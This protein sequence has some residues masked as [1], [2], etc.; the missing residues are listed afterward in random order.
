MLSDRDYTKARFRQSPPRVNDTVLKPLII[1]NIIVYVMQEMSRHTLT[2]MISLDFG[3]LMQGQVWRLGTHMFAHGGLGHIFFNMWG[4]WLFG[5]VVE[6]RIGGHKLLRLYIVSG[7]IGA[8]TWLMF[9]FEQR[10]YRIDGRL[11]T[12]Y[13]SVVGASGALFGILVAAAL[14]DPNRMFML[15]I[16]PVP[17]KLRTMAIIYGFIEVVAMF[18]QRQSNIAHLAHLG[19]MLGGYLYI[20]WVFRG[21]WAN[22]SRRGP[23]TWRM[24]GGRKPKWQA[25]KKK[26]RAQPPPPP[27]KKFPGGGDPMKEIDP[28]L[29]KIGKHGLESLTPHEREVLRQ[30]RE[31]LKKKH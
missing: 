10:L 7:L 27:P 24:P 28:I 2:T 16:P 26:P 23:G 11:F 4:L 1:V 17:I 14:L 8:S 20:R 12:D 9:N 6:E 3:S 22:V 18:N 30:V 15:L 19:G 5:Q 25:F 13:P 21:R 31:R 29:D